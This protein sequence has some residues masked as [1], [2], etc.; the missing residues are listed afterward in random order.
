MKLADKVVVITGSGGGIGEAC[1]RR[2]TAEGAKV[3]VA[4][5]DPDKVAGVAASIGSVGLAVD[6]RDEDNVRAVANLARKTYGEVDVWFSNAG[7]AGPAQPGD[8]QDNARWESFWALH[9]MSHVYAVRE[10]LPAMLER[11]DGYL[12]QTASVLALLTLPDKAAY[13]VTKHAALAL[14]EWLAANY[15]TRGIK[16][17][18]FCPGAML[19]P[20]L[21]AEGYPAD[22]PVLQT[23]LPPDKVADLL[24]QAIDAEKFLVLDSTIGTDA[25]LAKAR[26]YDQWLVDVGAFF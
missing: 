17:S 5:L 10:V 24:V 23:A 6:L 16:V 18:C 21:W 9:V 4:D 19:T 7:V 22:H 13:S 1:A 15:R 3:V 14:S 25:L 26:D 2:F 12:L 11:G 20:M 8:I